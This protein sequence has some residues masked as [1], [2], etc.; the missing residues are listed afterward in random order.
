MGCNVSSRFGCRLALLGVALGFSSLPATAATPTPA[1]ARTLA[2]PSA[3]PGLLEYWGGPARIRPKF[4]DIT[5]T[6][7]AAVTGPGT[8]RH[9]DAIRWT[10]WTSVSARGTGVLWIDTCEVSCAQGP[11]DR[12]RATLY[13]FRV[14][15]GRFTRLTIA[16]SY[17]SR[18]LPRT[19]KI[20]WKPGFGGQFIY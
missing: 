14:R 15:D 6:D 20:R 2:R 18:Y 7:G 12:Y 17:H 16:S 8:F 19:L 11:E 4:L 9:P 13:A 1:G 10:S 5:P 3:L